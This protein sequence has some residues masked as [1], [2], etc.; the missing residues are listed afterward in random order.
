MHDQTRTLAPSDLPIYSIGSVARLLGV[1]VYT[2]RMYEREGLV[3]PQK[4]HSHQRRY[5]ERDVERLRC[6]RQAIQEQGFTI[7]AIKTLYAMIPCW[8]IVGCTNEERAACPAYRGHEQPCWSYTHSDNIC[9]S[10]KCRECPAYQ[11]ISNCDQIKSSIIQS[12]LR[13]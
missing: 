4:S 5:S 6:I 1:S 7:S 8:E 13:R 12:T 11:L 2:L 9:A 3:L 10:R